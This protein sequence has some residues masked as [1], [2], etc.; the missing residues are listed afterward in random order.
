MP[1]YYSDFK[2]MAYPEQ[3]KAFTKREVVAPIHLRI[4]PIN[5]CNHDCW[6]CAYRVS[7]LQ[8]GED[9]NL[10]DKI[11][12]DKMLETVDDIVE[13]GV[14][15]VTFSGGGEPLIYKKLPECVERLAKGGVKVASLTNGENLSGKIADI[16]A[17][18]GTWIRISIDAW[19]DNSYGEARGIQDG[20]FTKVIK[21]MREFSRRN[22]NCVL[23]ISFIV[24]EKNY[25]HLYEACCIFKDAGV[26]HVKFSGVVTSNKISEVNKYHQKILATVQKEIKKSMELNDENF[27]VIDLYHELNERFE[28]SYRNCPN[29]L[30]VSVIG[31]DMN[32]YSCHDKAY[33]ENG[34]LGSLKDQSFKQF[35]FSDQNKNRLYGLDPSLSCRHH[36]T[37]HGKNVAMHE[38]I[39]MDKNHGVFI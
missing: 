38:I 13:M 19:D 33:T 29:L 8:L 1:D 17:E 36:C 34:L 16:F 28:K 14:K 7:N 4:K 20:K 35:W 21:N 11:P 37:A 30:Y 24:S 22:A 6:Y 23:G 5:R 39:S 32:V 2:F 31:A 9:I 10:Q 26:D 15:A 25:E 18:Y 3:L 12:Y 27:R